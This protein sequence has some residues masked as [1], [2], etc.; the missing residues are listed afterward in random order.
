MVSGNQS[1]HIQ[2]NICGPFFS[3]PDYNQHIATVEHKNAAVKYFNDRFDLKNLRIFPSFSNDVFK[4]LSDA[5]I[6]FMFLVGHLLSKHNAMLIDVHMFGLY[7]DESLNEE[8][9]N[10]AEAKQFDVSSKV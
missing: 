7:H 5:K 9:K 1:K 10:I 2:C 4:F 8:N 6:D 3:I